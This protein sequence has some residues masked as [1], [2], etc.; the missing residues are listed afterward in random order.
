MITI[1]ILLFIIGYTFIALE[2]SLGV[3]KTATALV[4]GMLLW[5]LCIFAGPDIIISANNTSFHEYVTANPSLHTLSLPGAKP[6]SILLT[7][8]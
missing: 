8:K 5:T 6:F 1:A 7:C 3:N 4:L 2:H